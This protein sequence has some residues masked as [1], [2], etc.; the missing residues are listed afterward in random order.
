MGNRWIE[1]DKQCPLNLSPVL[2]CPGTRLEDQEPH[3]GTHRALSASLRV[4]SGRCAQGC[5]IG[6]SGG[7]AHPQID[8]LLLLMP[9]GR[10]LRQPSAIPADSR[11]PSVNQH[12]LPFFP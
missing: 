3:L 5:C 8:A 11:G 12:S 10:G 9:K 2:F 7:L 6:S 1:R 4:T